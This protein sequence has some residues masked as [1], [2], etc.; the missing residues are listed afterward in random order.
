[1]SKEN[2]TFRSDV[3][4]GDEEIVR[5]MVVSTGFFYDFEIPVAVE[6]VMEKLELGDKSDYFFLFAE[7]GG[8]PVA[9]TCYGPIAGAEGSFDLFWIITHND[10][11]GQGIGRII[12]EKTEEAARQ[13]GAR[14]IIAET[15]S[16]EKYA[17]TRHFYL[18][19]G[20]TLE[21]KIDDFYKEGD[22]KVFFIKR[23]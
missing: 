9:Y 16:L 3:R 6:L 5:E 1:M 21:A 14:L 19:L 12:L 18:Q 8:N 7:I 11:R 2:L 20:Y 13:M 15:S 23:F 17:P 22:G 4:P 10:Y